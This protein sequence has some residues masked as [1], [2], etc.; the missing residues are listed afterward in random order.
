MYKIIIMDNLPSIFSM[1][2]IEEKY[3]RDDVHTDGVV[4][5]QSIKLR[6][7]FN[8]RENP[9]ESEYRVGKGKRQGEAFFLSRSL[10]SPQTA[11]SV[12]ISAIVLSGLLQ[13]INNRNKKVTSQIGQQLLSQALQP[14]R[15][16]EDWHIQKRGALHTA[17]LFLC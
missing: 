3:T 13:K 10:D 1:Q 15:C 14:Y 16:P 2:E 9:P 7:L 17:G 12:Y 6:Y 4:K 8:I 5:N 11:D